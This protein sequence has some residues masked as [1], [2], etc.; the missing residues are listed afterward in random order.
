[1]TTCKCC[2][3]NTIEIPKDVHEITFLKNNQWGF[4]FDISNGLSMS[5]YCHE[6]FP[7]IKQK[8]QE[9]EA[10]IKLEYWNGN[11]LRKKD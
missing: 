1:M 3:K 4:V 7:V 9:L 8:Y 10:M 2:E 6:C 5:Y 11:S